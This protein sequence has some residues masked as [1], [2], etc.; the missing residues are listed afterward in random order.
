M[1]RARNLVFTFVYNRWL[2]AELGAEV[3]VRNFQRS[4]APRDT[5]LSCAEGA[6]IHC[7]CYSS[8]L[9]LRLMPFAFFILGKNPA[10][11]LTFSPLIWITHGVNCGSQSNAQAGQNGLGQ[12]EDPTK[13]ESARN[14]LPPTMFRS[15]NRKP[16]AK[17]NLPGRRMHGP[18]HGFPWIFYL[19]AS[20][21][22]LHSRSEPIH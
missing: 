17:Q 3:V 16:I 14:I 21:T 1:E 20:V 2:R 11:L 7:E 15:A 5:F 19:R 10:A 18:M 9:V 8:H 6:P 22:I 4:R 13:R 12:I